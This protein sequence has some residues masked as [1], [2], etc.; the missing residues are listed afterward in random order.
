MI[1]FIMPSDYFNK[2][3]PDKGYAEEYMALKKAGFNVYLINV[4]DLEN[5]NVLPIL[6]NESLLYRG[7]MLSPENYKELDR[8]C[9]NKLKVKV[10]S[11]VNSHYLPKWYDS[12]KELTIESEITT[13]DE[14]TKKFQ[15]LKWDKAFIKD[16]VKSLK[17]GKGSIVDSSIDVNRA[18]TDIKK[19]KGYVEGGII[20]RRVLNLDIKS[21]KRYFVL[22]HTIYGSN[23]DQE[24]FD[25]V[26]EV[27]NKHHEFFYSVDVVRDVSGKLYVIEIG[28]GQVSDMVGWKMEDFIAIFKKLNV[29]LKV[30]IKIK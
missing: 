19:Y 21:E 9:G 3:L 18:L 28:D 26:S 23:E 8:V 22:S 7:W 27:A 30:N 29:E 4:D 16:Y 17:T 10:E 15:E 14:A 6:D 2:K 1:S 24:M 25:I 12:I 13:E 5:T 11:Y 20:F